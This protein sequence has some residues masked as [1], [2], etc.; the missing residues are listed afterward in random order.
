[1]PREETQKIRSKRG[2]MITEYSVQRLKVRSFIFIALRVSISYRK[3][4]FYNTYDD[5]VCGVTI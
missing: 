1:M 5:D 4:F 2:N 3:K